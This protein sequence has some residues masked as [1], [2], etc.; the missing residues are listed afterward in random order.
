M[1]R[2]STKHILLDSPMLIGLLVLVLSGLAMV[3]A[4]EI[5]Q[6][7]TP[8]AKTIYGVVTTEAGD[9]VDGATVIAHRVDTSG[10]AEIQ[11]SADGSYELALG[12]GLW[13]I[14]AQPTDGSTPSQWLY[15]DEPQQ[16][17]FRRDDLAD[18]QALDFVVA[19]AD[20]GV[21]GVVLMP[22]GSPPPFP[23]TVGLHNGEGFG[24]R[25]YADPVT[26][27]F[28]ISLPNGRYDVVVHPH[29]DGYLGPQLEPVHLRPGQTVDLGTIALIPLDGI[30][31][32]TVTDEDG[33]G[34]AGVP[35]TAWQRDRFAAL[36]TRTGEGGIYRLA[37]SRGA[38][39]VKPS[40]GPDSRYLYLGEGK[41]VKVGPGETVDGVDFE[42]LTADATIV[43]ILVTP[44]D[45]HA[46]DFTGW[47]TAVNV[48][49]PNI[50]NGAPIRAGRFAIHIP[51]GRYLV[52]TYLP[53]GSPY[54]STADI[55]ASVE[56]GETV[57]VT[58]PLK[59][60]DAAIAGALVD[61]RQ[62]L[63]PV[64]GVRGLVSGWS[65]HHWTTTHIQPDTGTY[66]LDVAAGIW[67][68][69]YRIGSHE[70]VKIGG[71]ANI[72]VA[73]GQTVRWP[74]LVTRRDA[75]ISGKVLSPDGEPVAGALVIAD[76]LSGDIA[77]LWL[78]TRTDREGQFRLSLP[79]GRYRVGATGG[80]P[81][82]IRPVEWRVNV[83]PG[84]VVDDIKLQFHKP[85]A[86]V[87]G[88]LTVLN[89]SAEGEALVWAWSERG[90][91]TKGRFP[92]TQVDS[93]GQAGGDYRLGVISGTTWHVGAIFETDQA[94][95]VGRD[96]VKVSGPSATLDLELTGPHPKP[97]PVVV[98]F[99][100]AHAQRLRLADGTVMFIPAG[101]MPVEG[102]VTL[103][104]VPLA[105]LPHQQHARIIRYGY[106]FFATDESGRPIEEQFDHDVL[107]LF[108][109]DGHDFNDL[110]HPIKPAYFSTTTNE[111]TFPERYVVD[112]Q[113]KI[114]IMAIDHFTNFALVEAPLL[115]V[116]VTTAVFLPLITSGCRTTDTA[117]GD[118]TPCALTKPGPAGVDGS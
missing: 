58:I 115:D 111:W 89:T 104:I 44:Y 38:W 4:K 54:L 118:P 13:A 14:T 105:T 55:P 19:V 26:G 88:A 33:N 92:V 86:E 51:G 98:T 101:A 15:P 11:T 35:V 2:L 25:V 32:G 43:G 95:W 93:G 28:K 109:Y 113:R 63:H 45:V 117:P 40:P 39:H 80:E 16:V 64:T 30:I 3:E 94:Y 107:I 103:R 99:D 82:W 12:P 57:T 42:V 6:Q 7:P 73:S 1:T 21:K 87:G 56:T 17:D 52:S 66:K 102:M 96:D 53:P 77:D 75:G 91:F 78:R 60:K 70:Y 27:E 8:P 76:G 9:P 85:N 37:V 5:A 84:S 23:V 41:T 100:A 74:L 46:L 18:R 62:N 20:A 10:L 61:P 47:A 50:H 29:H 114:V 108:K 36:S 31:T 81:G 116:P 97:P 71:P 110:A 67:R 65:D 112:P 79:Y 24:R 22:N 34:V 59:K 72:P 68:V 90:G 48:A 106:A 49:N 69:N 83:A